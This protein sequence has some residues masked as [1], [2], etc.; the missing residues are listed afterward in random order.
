MQSGMSRRSCSSAAII[1]RK[2]VIR[3]SVPAHARAPG[4][5]VSRQSV[6]REHF[7][8]SIACVPREKWFPNSKQDKSSA[9]SKKQ[10]VRPLNGA[11]PERLQCDTGTASYCRMIIASIFEHQDLHIPEVARPTSSQSMHPSIC[12]EDASDPSCKRRSILAPHDLGDTKSS[13]WSHIALTKV[14]ATSL[15][16]L[17]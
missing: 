2:F 15:T 12:E 6:F 10:S 4:S 17:L 13:S 14:S 3:W 1:C 5:R 8:R 9:K 11:F 16:D 7:R